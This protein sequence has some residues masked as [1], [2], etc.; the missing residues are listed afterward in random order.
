MKLPW[1]SNDDSAAEAADDAVSDTVEDVTSTSTDGDSKGSAY[2]PGK[3]RA[4]PSRREAQGRKRGPVAPPPTTRSE[5]RARKKDLKTSMTKEEKRQAS[6]ERRSQR[7]EQR[8]RM[9]A[10]DEKYLPARDK[11]KVKRFARD[12]V[13]SRRNFAGLFMPFAILL[14]VVMFVP[15]IAIYANFVLLAFVLCMAIDSYILGRIVN[16]RVRERYPDVDPSET[17]FR[18][19]WYSFTRAMQ[20]RRMRAPKPSVSPGDEV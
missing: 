12:I 16:R 2:T 19:G 11:G 8:E 1:K 15:S 13:D 14:I 5:A 9:M 3:G 7:M 17:G 4:T 10:G 18:L 6:D 20:L